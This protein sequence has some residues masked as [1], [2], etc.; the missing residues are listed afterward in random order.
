MEF[1]DDRTDAQKQTHTWI[2]AGTDRFMS[3]WGRAEGG[4]SY[5]AWACKPEHRREVLNWV[6]SRGDMLRVREVS[7]DWRPRGKGHT[8]IYVVTEKH[9]A[10]PH[11]DK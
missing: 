5:A 9:P 4:T 11:W 6:E 7:P 10:W 2:V 3:G 8:H 1:V